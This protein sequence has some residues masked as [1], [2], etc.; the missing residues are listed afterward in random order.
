MQTITRR[1]RAT[2]TAPLT[3][4]L[5]VSALAVGLITAGVAPVY[6]DDTYQRGPD[7]TQESIEA[8]LGPF[9]TEQVAVPPGEVDEF[10]GG[11]VYYPTDTTVGTFGAVA[12]SPGLWDTQEV[13]SWLGPRLASQGFVVITIDTLTTEDTTDQRGDE[14]LAALDHLETVPEVSGRV[15]PE[16]RAVMG[17]SLG[18]GGSL[19]AATDDPSLR[20][21]IPMAPYQKDKTF[22]EVTT[23]TLIFGAE[24]DKIA[25]VKLHAEP[26]YASIPTTTDKAYLELRD[27]PH[28]V[29]TE[30]DTTI[31]S[32]SIAWLKLYVDDDE[33]YAQFLCPEPNPD[34]D[35]KEYRST[36]CG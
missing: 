19:E 34:A 17:H 25:P 23:P 1:L 36:I 28:S 32:Y 18:G 35:I 21:A 24:S 16:R 15:D 9:E 10:G 29:V 27:A 8:E 30:P 4:P 7:P 2:L 14:L 11:T 20:A 3:L 13:V 26:L 22:P 6:A 12:I 33:R 31:A 5:S